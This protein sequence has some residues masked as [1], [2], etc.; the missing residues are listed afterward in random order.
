[1]T[2]VEEIVL[3]FVF[4]RLLICPPL[5]PNTVLWCSSS[6]GHR[7]SG[8]PCSSLDLPLGPYTLDN[9]F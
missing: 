6:S 2:A 3:D 7:V 1:M 4:N 5:N 9:A 8:S